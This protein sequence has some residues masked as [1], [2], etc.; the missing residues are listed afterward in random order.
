MA[1]G[2][3][4]LALLLFLSIDAMLHGSGRAPITAAAVLVAAAPLVT[5]FTL[6]PQVRSG[7]KR[8]LVRNPFRTIDAPWGTVESLTAALSVELRAGGRKFIVW[9]LPVSMRQRKRANKQAMIA[10]GDR[11][12]GGGAGRGGREGGRLGFGLMGGADRRG[13]GGFGRPD[14]TG[15]TQAWADKTVIELNERAEMF[16]AERGAVDEGAAAVTDQ[17]KV[18]WTWPIIAPLAAGIIALIVILA[19]G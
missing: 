6:W 15:P 3:F 14:D 2:V 13:G 19:T 8:L 17:V 9:A 7:E 12:V 5:A 1:G 10:A 11:S 16:R 18:T 4:L